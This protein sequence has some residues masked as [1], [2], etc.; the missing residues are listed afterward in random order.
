VSGA[1]HNGRVPRR[2]LALFNPYVL[3]SSERGDV[4]VQSD[5]RRPLGFGRSAEH[6]GRQTSALAH[7]SPR[8]RQRCRYDRRMPDSEIVQAWIRRNE[9]ARREDRRRDSERSMSARLEEAVRLSRIA[10]ELEENLSR[11]PDVRA[12]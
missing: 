7:A 12:G 3:R 6:A 8:S 10:S 2:A 11:E 5:H 9:A 4:G 1:L